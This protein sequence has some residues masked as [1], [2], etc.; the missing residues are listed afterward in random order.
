M[1]KAEAK[2]LTRLRDA[3]AL[4]VPAVIAVG[5]AE[6]TLFILLEWLP[7]G[8]GT[9]PDAA[10]RLGE[11]LAA[12]HAQ[13]QSQH[14]LDHDNFIGRLPQANSLTDRWT[15]FYCNQRIRAQMGIARQRGE[16]PKQ[17][18]HLLNALLEKLPSLLPDATP[19]LLHGDLWGGNYAVLEDGS[20]AIYD[21]AVYYGHREVELAFTEL[22]GGFPSSF[23]DA[24]NATLPLDP[25]YA[26]RKRLYQLYPLMVHMNL[27]GG[28]YGSQVDAIARH[29]ID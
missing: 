22:F 2:G 27:F 4:R 17:R 18:E 29:Y 8:R 1:F 3:Q 23:Y 20:P 15:D 14:G 19:S 24:Y 21:P 5:E 9:S 6:E 25:G 13:A 26:E 28:H 12:L 11:G 7:I 10:K 16:L